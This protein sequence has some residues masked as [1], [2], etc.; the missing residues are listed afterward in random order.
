MKKISPADTGL[1]F[2]GEV[3]AADRIKSAT[4]EL[5]ARSRELSTWAYLVLVAMSA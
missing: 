5:A 2:Y 3:A 1:I 4:W